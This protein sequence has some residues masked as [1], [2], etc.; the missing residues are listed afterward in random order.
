VLFFDAEFN[1]QWDKR[2]FFLEKDSYDSYDNHWKR[3]TI[4]GFEKTTI[5]D[6]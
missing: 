3:Y 5:D 6:F 4:I 2:R 1:N